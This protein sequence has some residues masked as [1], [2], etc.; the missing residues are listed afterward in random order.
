MFK[1]LF[2]S[3]KEAFRKFKD[4]KGAVVTQQLRKLLFPIID[5]NPEQHKANKNNKSWIE[6]QGWRLPEKQTLI[7]LAT[8]LVI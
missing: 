3:T 5:T 7:E 1:L 6:E 8:Y 2:S 4:S